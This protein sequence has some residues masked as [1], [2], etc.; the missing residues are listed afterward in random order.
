M[1][2]IILLLVVLVSTSS[3]SQILKPVKWITEVE[4][5]SD[6]EYD[7]IFKAKIDPNYHLYS[8]NVPDDGPQPTVFVF[9]KSQ[10][11]DLI[12][13]VKED[14]GH[15]VYDQF[16]KIE[17][18]YFDTNAVFRQ[19]IKVKNKEPFNILGEIEFMTCDDTKCVFG[20]DDFEF[21]I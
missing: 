14:K 18:K 7:L 20:Y 3:Y 10:S 4:K 17:V 2:K 1:K 5:I 13:K 16:F 9:E 11:F 6:T 15:T 21:D 19:R 8:Q 12:G